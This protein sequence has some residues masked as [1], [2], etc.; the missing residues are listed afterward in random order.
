MSSRKELLPCEDNERKIGRTANSELFDSIE[1]C[2]A[3]WIEIGKKVINKNKNALRKS[4]AGSGGW[5]FD[6]PPKHHCFKKLDS[7]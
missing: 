6:Q 1:Q 2:K 5:A 4:L 7:N 3:M